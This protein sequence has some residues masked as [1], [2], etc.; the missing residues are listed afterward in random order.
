MRVAEPVFF[1]L[2]AAVARTALPAF[3]CMCFGR[4]GF[5]GFGSFGGAG[6]PDLVVAIALSVS[7]REGARWELDRKCGNLSLARRASRPGVAL[8][9]ADPEVGHPPDHRVEPVR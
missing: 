6:S 2:P 1:V 3:A 9:P 8:R 7:R 4:C 5:V